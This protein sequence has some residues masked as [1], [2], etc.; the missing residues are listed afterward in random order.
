[1]GADQ[2]REGTTAG[3]EQPD[4]LCEVVQPEIAEINPIDP[5]LLKL[6]VVQALAGPGALAI[7]ILVLILFIIAEKTALGTVLKEL[8]H[9]PRGLVLDQVIDRL[10]IQAMQIRRILE[11][12]E[13]P[14]KRIWTD[15]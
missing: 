5:A 14:L 8:Q 11:K 13:I 2:E 1:M 7:L 10:R 4:K 15:A 3:L 9:L 6:L 12:H